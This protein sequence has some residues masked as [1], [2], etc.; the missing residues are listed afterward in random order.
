[1]VFSELV[2]HTNN[3]IQKLLMPKPQTSDKYACSGAYKLTCPD[4]NKAYI[5]QTGRSF[6]E[7]FKEHKYAF[8][9]NSHMS[10]YAK[11]ILEHSH[12]FRPIQDTM[13]I[14]QYQGKGIHL[15]TV[16]QFHIYVKFSKNNHLND[17][18]TISPNKIFDA[19][20]KPQQPAQLHPPPP[21]PPTKY[22]SFPQ[23]AIPLTYHPNTGRPPNK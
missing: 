16:E 14:L 7:R 23:V 18:H 6:N 15:N 8:K 9:T 12:S 20:L 4:C 10:N 1:M 21:P 22:P 13:Q 11:H 17:E 5:G 19:L 3:T 2:L